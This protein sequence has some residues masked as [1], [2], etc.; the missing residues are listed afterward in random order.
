MPEGFEFPPMGSAAYR[1]VLWMSLNLPPE[2]ERARE[3]HSLQVT[4]RL[5]AGAS[6]AQAQAE[7]DAIGLRMAQAYPRENSGWG[8]KITRLT[9]GREL[10]QV[11]PSLLL[12]MAAASFV[13][14]IACAN[15]A[16]LLVAR[17]VERGREMAVRRALGVTGRRLARQLLTESGLLALAGGAAGVLLALAALPLL[18]SSLPASMPRAGEI[19][20]NGT[21]LAF[22]AGI[23]MLT[24]LLFGLAPVMWPDGSFGSDSGGRRVTARNRA[25]GVLVTAEVALA[26][27]LLAGAGLLIES[28][29]RVA[30]VDLGFREEHAL[31]MRLQ[32]TKSRYPDAPG[33]AA[34][35]AE[36]LRQAQALPGVQYAGTVSSLPMGIVM[37][38][39]EFEIEG[40]PETAR[41]KPFADYAN[42]STDYLRAMGIGLMRGR[43]F[44]AGE[45]DRLRL[46]W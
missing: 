34:F 29:R 42:V 24:G 7:L 10:E 12:V 31:T 32:L 33:V 27:V 30:N 15:V 45:T 43:Y 35:R 9:D 6:I 3:L 46:R 18:K 25:V 26:L 44:D 22:A 13:L 2:E 1:P 4:A 23:S 16:N 41:Q 5:K 40:R 20:I 17:A 39:T 38:G 14:L 19:G 37:Q 28:F 36:L 8:I 11:R 21:V